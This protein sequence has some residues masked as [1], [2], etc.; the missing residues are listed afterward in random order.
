MKK[1]NFMPGIEPGVIRTFT[2]NLFNVFEPKPERICIEDIA[3]ALSNICRFAGHTIMFYSVAEHSMRV[4]ELVEPK[5]K[6]AA[7]LHDAAEAYLLDIPTP[8]KH[9]FPNYRKA[10][11]KLMEMIAEKFGF[12][13][14]LH[15]SVELADKAMLK[16]EWFEFMDVQKPGWALDHFNARA[17]FLAAFD[18]I[19][20]AMQSSVAMRQERKVFDI[21]ELQK[22]SVDAL[23]HLAA[24]Y[25]ID[26]TNSRQII[27]Y[28]I[29]GAQQQESRKNTTVTI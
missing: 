1:E 20:I 15:N 28:G 22:L 13:Y 26:I 4:A 9:L 10:E 16:T 14:P 2:G 6:L 19:N 17:G 7:L 25:D 3:H 11:H 12:E 5:Y 8:I 29:L 23:H 24:S 21:L 27:I 18:A